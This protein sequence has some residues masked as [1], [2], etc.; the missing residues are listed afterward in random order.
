V[1]TRRLRQQVTEIQAARSDAEQTAQG[2]RTELAQERSTVAAIRDELT[3]LRESL[4]SIPVPSLRP[5]LLLPMRRG[6]GEVATIALPKNVEQVPFRLRLEPDD[7]QRYDTAL[8]DSATGQVVWRSGRV[9]ARSGGGDRYL[10]L[11][12]PAS[13]LKSQAYVLELSGRRPDGS[14]EFVTS[15]AFRV[16]RE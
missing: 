6:A 15:Y 8:R 10:E 16:T 4:T 1:E 5:F 9:G 14:A 11:Q 13:L 2:L 3:R 12:V 7:F